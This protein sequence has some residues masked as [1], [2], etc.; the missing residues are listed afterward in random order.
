MKEKKPK[1]SEQVQIRKVVMDG[2]RKVKAQTGTPLATQF[3]KG[4][5]ELYGDKTPTT[6]T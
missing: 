5:K 2:A 6:T 3:E 1:T 4:W